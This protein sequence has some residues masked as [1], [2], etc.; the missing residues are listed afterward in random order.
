MFERSILASFTDAS[1]ESQLLQFTTVGMVDHELCVRIFFILFLKFL[2]VRMFRDELGDVP[3]DISLQDALFQGTQRTVGVHVLGQVRYDEYH[4][5]AEKGDDRTR[6]MV[7]RI[8]ESQDDQYQQ[9]NE[10][11]DPQDSK[12]TRVDGG[13]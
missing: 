6:L 11:E 7:V 10:C 9:Q 5:D 2:D 3:G 8:L 12:E 1:K 4:L 13:P